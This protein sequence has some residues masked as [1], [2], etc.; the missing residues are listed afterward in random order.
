MKNQHIQIDQASL[1]TSHFVTDDGVEIFE[2]SWLDDIDQAR[3]VYS[4][5][6]F[7]REINQVS[8]AAVTGRG[9][10]SYLWHELTV[11]FMSDE[12]LLTVGYEL[13]CYLGWPTAN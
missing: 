6:Y 10:N 4:W 5:P 13:G 12:Q 11:E 9:N 2:V 3:I 1:I 8:I 7:A